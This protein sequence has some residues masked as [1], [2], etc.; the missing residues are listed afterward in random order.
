MPFLWANCPISVQKPRNLLTFHAEISLCYFI[1]FFFCCLR[2]KLAFCGTES[3]WLWAF[4]VACCWLVLLLAF[5]K[6]HSFWFAGIAHFSSILLCV[7]RS[8]MCAILVLSACMRVCELLLF[9]CCRI[10]PE[11]ITE[12]LPVVQMPCCRQLPLNLLPRSLWLLPLASKVAI[13]L[14]L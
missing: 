2:P 8:L 3:S 9:L 6:L 12:A 7:L 4:Y 5:G 14:V 13:C 1:I 11:V 10:C